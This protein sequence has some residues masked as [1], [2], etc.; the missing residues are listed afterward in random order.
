MDYMRTSP[1]LSSDPS[2]LSGGYVIEHSDCHESYNECFEDLSACLLQ[3]ITTAKHLLAAFL[4]GTSGPP[5]SMDNMQIGAVGFNSETRDTATRL[6]AALGEIE[7]DYLH[8]DDLSFECHCCLESRR[9]RR[10]N[11]FT[12]PDDDEVNLCPMFFTWDCKT[13]ASIIF[14]EITHIVLN[15]EDHAY[16]G[17]P[18]WS[19]LSNWKRRDNADSWEKFM[20]PFFGSCKCD[21]AAPANDVQYCAGRWS[22]NTNVGCPKGKGWQD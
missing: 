17:D 1:A 21:C 10:A 20:E 3:G 8:D 7:V 11:A 14:H 9:K 19:G 16:Y 4:A 13:M 5:S 12:H 22:N 6:L 18:G 2:G 15:T